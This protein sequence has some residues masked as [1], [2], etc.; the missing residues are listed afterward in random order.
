MMLKLKFIWNSATVDITNTGLDTIIFGLEGVLGILDLRS[1]WVYKI[2]QGVILQN[3]SKYCRFK[4]ADVLCEQFNKFINTLKK[5]SQSEE[6]KEKY[7]WLD[8]S[9]E[10]KHLTDREIL[11]ST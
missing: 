6:T 9:E 10:R 2:K 11:E 5:E 3:L 7:P 8:P 1:L 4:K